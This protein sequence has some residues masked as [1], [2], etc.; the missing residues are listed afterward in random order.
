MKNWAFLAK[1]N[2]LKPASIS[3]HDSLVVLFSIAKPKNENVFA[4]PF[5]KVYMIFL[6]S[7]LY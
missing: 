4:K 1:I 3:L 7:I 2:T 5:Q 6:F